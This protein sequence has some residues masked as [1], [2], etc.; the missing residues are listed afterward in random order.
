MRAALILVVFSLCGAASAATRRVP[1]DYATI[2]AAVDAAKPGDHVR[3]AAGSW[4]GATVN[5]PLRLQGSH[6]VIVGC[7]APTLDGGPLRVGFF[8][9]SGASGSEIRDFTFDGAGV[10]N[11]NTTPLAFA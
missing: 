5:K 3:V 9:A 11:Q 2:Q 4:C 7:A 1:Q 10:S 6:A 8:L